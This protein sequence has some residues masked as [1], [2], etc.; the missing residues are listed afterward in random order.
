M[1][2]Q[3][4]LSLKS[5]YAL[6]SPY[7][8][9]FQNPKSP[10]SAAKGRFSYY[11]VLKCRGIETP[12]VSKQRLASLSVVGGGSVEDERIKSV[13]VKEIDVATLG[14][15]CVDIVLNVPKLP[16]KPLDERK[17]Y[18]DE[19]SKSP[20]DKVLPFIFSLKFVF[21]FLTLWLAVSCLYSV[22]MFYKANA[23]FMLVSFDFVALLLTAVKFRWNDHL[24]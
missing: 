2:N 23:P 20:P 19:L 5:S 7:P 15:L 8:N 9:S 18:M 3:A 13:G 14:N 17:A 24:T 4:A 22:E 10:P 6:F 21:L 1:H 11:S 16:P 12:P